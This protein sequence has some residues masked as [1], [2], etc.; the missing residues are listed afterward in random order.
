MKTLI[1]LSFS[2][3]LFLAAGYFLTSTITART[4]HICD[5]QLALVDLANTWQDVYTVT[6]WYPYR[7]D[8]AAFKTCSGSSQYIR[9][10]PVDLAAVSLLG[11]LVAGFIAYR[12]ETMYTKKPKQKARS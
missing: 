2:V 4:G 12:S 6:E 8:G 7:D 5:D 3:L 1:A 10:H 9:Y 11:A